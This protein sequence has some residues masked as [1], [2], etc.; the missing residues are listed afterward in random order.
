VKNKL[1][2]IAATQTFNKLE[3]VIALHCPSSNRRLQDI[4]RFV[5]DYP[6]EMAPKKVAA[7][8]RRA[9]HG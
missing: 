8:A 5:L 6:A 2:N 9:S 7:I 3:D 1:Q 4:A